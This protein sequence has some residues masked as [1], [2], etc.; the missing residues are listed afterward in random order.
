MEVK[1]GHLEK[2]IQTIVINRD[3]NSQKNNLVHPF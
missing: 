2:R 3:E 1:L